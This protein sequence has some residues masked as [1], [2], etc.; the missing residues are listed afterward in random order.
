MTKRHASDQPDVDIT[1]RPGR[2]PGPGPAATSSTAGVT[3]R[4]NVFADH[5][6]DFL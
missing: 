3:A 4:Q 6:D 5:D 1:T 2:G